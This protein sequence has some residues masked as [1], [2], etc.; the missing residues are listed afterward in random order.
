ML[1]KSKYRYY[2]SFVDIIEQFGK[3]RVYMNHAT[4]VFIAEPIIN[5]VLKQAFAYLAL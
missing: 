1:L 5:N 3:F 2:I 4:V